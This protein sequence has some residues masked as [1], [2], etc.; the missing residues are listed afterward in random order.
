MS[1]VGARAGGCRRWFNA[2]PPGQSSG[3]LRQKLMPDSTSRAPCSTF[4]GVSRLMRPSSSSSP[5]SPHVER[6]GRRVHRFVTAVLP[7][8]Y[9]VPT[10]WSSLFAK[11][12]AGGLPMTDKDFVVSADGHLL[13]PPDLFRTRLPE[14]LRERAV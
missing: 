12:R 13:E 4:S 5:Q 8:R 2:I 3:R 1:S 14:H 9:R 7:R 11:S 6:S 10:G